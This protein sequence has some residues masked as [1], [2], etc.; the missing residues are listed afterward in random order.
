MDKEVTRGNDA[1]L[2]NRSNIYSIIQTKLNTKSSTEAELVAVDDVK[3]QV[4]CT[5]HFLAAQCN[6]YPHNISR[7]QKYHNTIRKQMDIQFKENT[8]V[9][10]RLFFVTDKIKKVEVKVAFC[11]TTAMLASF[12]T[13]PLQGAI[14]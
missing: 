9:N 14:F 8:T 10:V 12:F 7:K 3:G 11:P 1:L 4:L 5:I 2:H 6:A 13:K